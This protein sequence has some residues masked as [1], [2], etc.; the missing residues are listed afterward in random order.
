MTASSFHDVLVRRNQSDP[1]ALVK[2]LLT[3]KNLTFVPAIK[4]VI[5][6]EEIAEQDYVSNMTILHQ[7]FESTLAGLVINPLYPYLRAS[8]DG[9]T[10]CQCCAQPAR[11]KMSDRDCH[12][13]DLKKRKGFFLN[14]QGLIRSNKYFTQVQGELMV[15]EKDFCD[16]VVWTPKGIF[17]QRIFMDICFRERLIKKLTA[18]YVE[19]FFPELITNHLQCASSVNEDVYCFS[20]RRI[21]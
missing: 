20:R 15:C 1:S 2:K 17:I 11:D 7:E 8:P 5:D 19:H 9:F 3:R 10:Q 4:W 12:P 6:S 13:N 18:F 16:F 21:W 14:K